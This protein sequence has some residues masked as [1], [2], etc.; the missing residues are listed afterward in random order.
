M[1][2]WRSAEGESAVEYKIVTLGRDFPEKITDFAA[3]RNYFLSRYDW[4][5]FVDDDEEASD[6]LLTHLQNL[7][8][9]FPYYWVRRF[10]LYNGR[11]RGLWNPDFAPRLVSS[12]VR[13]VGRVHERIVPKE[14]H[15]MIDF[16]IIHNHLGVPTYRNYWYQDNLI[17]RM[18]LGFK[19]AIEVVRDR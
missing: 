18:W 1:R 17:Y 3:A 19:K 8:P 10:N 14:P 9:R 12:K 7:V 4:V 6:M 13:F 11:Y 15:G 16:P 5:L 2:R